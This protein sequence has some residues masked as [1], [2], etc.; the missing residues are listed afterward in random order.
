[1]MKW[2]QIFDYHFLQQ[3]ATIDTHIQRLFRLGLY[4]DMEQLFLISAFYNG[5]YVDYESELFKQYFEYFQQTDDD[6]I[7]AISL[8][9][10]AIIGIGNKNEQDIVKKGLYY[11][12]NLF[13]NELESKGK[14]MILILY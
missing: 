6:F 14:N 2:Y 10:K 9:E 3:M 4:E 1:M 8:G 7:S 12:K 13:E 5:F 11:Y